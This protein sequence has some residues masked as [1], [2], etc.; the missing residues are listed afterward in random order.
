MTLEELYDLV[1]R[2]LFADLAY[3][4]EGGTPT[5]RRVFCTW[6]K[7]LGT[8]LISTNTSSRHVGALLKDSRASLYFADGETF[9]GLCLAGTAQVCTDPAHK[10]LLWHDGDEKYYPLGVTDP[11]YCVIEFRAEKGRYYRFD[12]IGDFTRQ[13]LDRFDKDKE[14]TDQYDR[15]NK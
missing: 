9:E 2:S 4:D 5:V 11:D 3:L 10:E 14:L 8:H 13:E 6:H 15:L 7:G 12:G 1:G